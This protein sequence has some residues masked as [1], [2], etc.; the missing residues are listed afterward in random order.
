[1]KIQNKA[2]YRVAGGLKTAR[3]VSLL[4]LTVFLFCM[5]FI[6]SSEMTIDHFKYL[7]RNL[8]F[9][10]NTVF[11]VGETVYVDSDNNNSFSG[12]KGGIAVLGSSKISLYDMT[13]SATLSEYHGYKSPA[14]EVSDKYM[15]VYDRGGSGFSVYGA[16]NKLESLE[17]PSPVYIA[18]VSDEGTYAVVC[19]SA[20]DEFYSNV[21]VYNSN[22]ALVNKIMKYKYVTAIDLSENGK[23]LLISSVYIGENGDLKSEVT[24]M[25][26]GSERVSDTLVVDGGVV[27]A[28]SFFDDGSF[29]L[30]TDDALRFYNKKGEYKK[31]VAHELKMSFFAVSGRGVS[32]VYEDTGDQN[33]LIS[34]D[35]SGEKTSSALFKGR[36]LDLIADEYTAYALTENEVIA[37][38]LSGGKTKSIEIP[39]AI[40]G[41]F[42]PYLISGANGDVYVCSGG[43]ASRLED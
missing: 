11:S 39:S 9:N 18:N 7:L 8:E 24:V 22:F 37:A 5:Y 34:Y 13:S 2:Y 21:Y 19:S 15:L 32:L 17:T 10:P 16:F 43:T 26:V 30:L 35:K 6:Y 40:K 4:F 3:Y 36:V 27:Y 20:E 29:F 14:F 28:C 1:M 23:R 38:T 12:Y 31:S 42:R 25:S 33:K 41:A